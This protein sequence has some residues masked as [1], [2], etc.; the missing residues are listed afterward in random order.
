M[1]YRRPDNHRIV[2]TEY[3]T[4]YSGKP[5][6]HFQEGNRK[7]IVTVMIYSMEKLRKHK[8][9]SLPLQATNLAAY[10]Q[11]FLTNRKPEPHP[12]P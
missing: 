3:T 9:K 2:A 6:I 8:K 4:F 1:L 10:T 12:P 7:W 5:V 11:V